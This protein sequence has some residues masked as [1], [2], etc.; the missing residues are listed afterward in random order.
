MLNLARE[1]MTKTVDGFKAANLALW[2]EWT[3]IHVRSKFYDVEGFKRGEV[4]L[5]S[6]EREELG[7]V[8]GKS[9]LHLQCHFGLGTLSWARLGATV[10]GADFSAKSIE[11]ARA[12]ADELGIPAHFVCSDVESLPDNLS[13][14]FDIVFTS[15]G[16]LPWLPDLK[17]WAEVIAHFLTP[18][19][20]FYIAEAHPISYIFDD[21]EGVNDLVVKYPYFARDEPIEWK[22]Q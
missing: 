18:G 1:D 7:D 9:L 16:V 10:T 12:L 21:T 14:Q 15:Y 4:R 6:L 11:Q 17:R 22:I 20:I 19:G 8:T 3:S 5:D 13:G 2:D